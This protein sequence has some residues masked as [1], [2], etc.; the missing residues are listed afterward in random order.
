MT[1]VAQRNL[2]VLRAGDSSLHP[3]WLTLP[4]QEWKFDLWIDYYA[5]T[6]PG[7]YRD[8]CDWYRES[9][10]T[11]FPQLYSLIKE[12]LEAVQKYNAI[13]FPDD[14]L[15]CDIA[16]IN[17]L[18]MLFHKYHLDL[19]QPSLSQDSIYSFL[20]TR[21]QP[22]CTLR[23]TNFVE[24]M[25]PLFRWEAL[26]KCLDT[27]IESQSGWGLCRIWPKLLGYPQDKIAVIDGVVVQHLRK[28]G[29]G[30]LYKGLKTLPLEELQYLIKKYQISEFKTT[31]YQS[32]KGDESN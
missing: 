3:Q 26:T 22:E 14:D 11:K 4:K 28:L 16:V 20:I 8:T 13:W 15:G 1:M 5:G 18:F 10:G 19:A 2:V 7:K 30:D 9:G 23:Y 17:N 6:E 25:M 21:N 31:V 32:I 29:S 24:T 12:N 27:F